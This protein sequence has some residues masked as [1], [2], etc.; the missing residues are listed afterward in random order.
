MTKVIEFDNCLGCPHS[1]YGFYIS[2]TKNFIDR[3]YCKKEYKWVLEECVNGETIPEIP[4][5]CKLKDKIN[6]KS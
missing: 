5:W 4:E 6:F 1:S 2:E 3:I